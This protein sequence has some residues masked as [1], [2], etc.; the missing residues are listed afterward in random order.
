M[1]VTVESLIIERSPLGI[2]AARELIPGA[3]RLSPS[4]GIRRSLE[5]INLDGTEPLL[6]AIARGPAR[7]SCRHALRLADYPG[8]RCKVIERLGGTGAV[9]SE[10]A[11]TAVGGHA[12]QLDGLPFDAKPAQDA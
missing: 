2:H 9:Q 1:S 5:A 4:Q 6:G 7:H 12:V 8:S 3:D 11:L 10:R